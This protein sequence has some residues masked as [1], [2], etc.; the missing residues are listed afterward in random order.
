M[1]R[2]P[3]RGLCVTIGGIIV[4][5]V[6]LVLV[7]AAVAKHAHP[8]A[9]ADRPMPTVS[10]PR[11]HHDRVDGPTRHYEYVFPDGSMSVY[12]IDQGHRLVQ[13]VSLPTTAGVRGVAASPRTHRLYISYG[14]DGGAH[15]N[16]S[17][18]AYNL[19]TAQVVWARTYHH[20]I[21]SLAISPDGTT[22]YM[23]DGELSRDGTW[24]VVN[25]ATGRDVGTIKAGT[26]PHN[27][28]VSLDGSLVYLGGRD[29]TYFEV[30][31]TRTKQV[32][33]KV[34]PF[35]SG[36]RPFTVNGT[37]TLVYTSV[38]GFLGFQVGDI[39]TGKVLYTVPIRGFRVPA[40]FPA[41]DPS[42]GLSLS[43]DERELYVLDAPNSE[44][45]VFAVAG[46]PRRPPVQVANIPLA[47]PM[48]GYEHPCAYDCFKDGWLQ[49]SRD[50]RFVYVGD[51]GD[52]IDTATRRVVAHLPALARTRKMLE[53]DWR[54][55][56]PVFTTTRT[57]VGYITHQVRPASR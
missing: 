24:Y 33:K 6:V 51:E 42:H 57:G 17:L 9:P 48:P 49:H 37:N 30:A 39:T 14:G 41:S 2:R 38:T 11:M 43:P 18:L 55:G 20:G 45:H 21:D 31:S 50:G 19:L 22:I 36:I 1:P 53:I 52:V 44:V 4:L 8:T 12:D 16:G 28:V 32:I 47:Q 40:H 15:G 27:T 10:A 25:A 35:K 23:P 54:H 29:Y 46:V 34:G 56:V 13:Q 26:G 7:P 3:S 5:V